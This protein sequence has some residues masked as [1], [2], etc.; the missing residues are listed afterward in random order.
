MDFFTYLLAKSIRKHRETVV[1]ACD[2]VV[3]AY[4][5]VLWRLEFKIEPFTKEEG[6]ARE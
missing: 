5:E 4:D 2:A 3:R 1:G 6:K